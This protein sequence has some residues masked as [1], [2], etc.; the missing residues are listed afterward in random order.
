MP[1]IVTLTVNPTI[2]KSANAET[3]ASEIKIRCT[4]PKFDP[5]GGGINVSRAIFKIGGESTAVFTAGGGPGDMLDRLLTDE[6]VTTQRIPIAGLTRENLTVFETS[7]E[8]QYRFGMPGPNLSEEE[9]Q[10][11]IDAVLALQP[12][13]IV[14]SGSLAPNMPV[15]FYAQLARQAKNSAQRVIVDTSGEALEA[16]KEAELFLMKPN[17]RELELLSGEKFRTEDHIVEIARRLISEGMAQTFVISMGSSGALLVTAD[18]AARMRPPVVPIQSK[19]G[20]GDSMVGGI[21]WALSEG[22][23]LRTATRYGIAAGTAAVMTPGTEL[24]R[25]EDVFRI[26]DRIAVLDA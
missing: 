4:D 25:R 14:G 26:Y 10:R 22:H 21:V 19:V 23:D 8:L 3:V 13:T 5:G 2:D 7:S 24:C 18:D 6:G 20:A 9:W 17:L 15:D 16:C 1:G 11:C 12:E